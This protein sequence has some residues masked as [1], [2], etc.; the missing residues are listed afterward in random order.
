[1]NPLALIL[2]RLVFKKQSAQEIAMSPRSGCVLSE[3]FNRVD[4]HGEIDGRHTLPLPFPLAHTLFPLSRRLA[5]IYG[6]ED[7]FCC[8]DETSEGY[9][10][11]NRERL[12]FRL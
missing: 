7:G 9:P 4:R 3:Y 5:L 10:V 8:L 6:S 1:L 12:C 11:R 2:P